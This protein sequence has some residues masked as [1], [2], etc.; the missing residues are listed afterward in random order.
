MSHFTRSPPPSQEATPPA[1][2]GPSAASTASRTGRSCAMPTISSCWCTAP[3]STPRRCVR[4][5]QPCWHRW[6]CGSH[7]PRPGSCTWTRG[8]TSRVPHPAAP[9]EGYEQAARVHVHRRSANPLSQGEDPC[10]DPQ[11]VT[12]TNGS[13][14][15]ARST[16][17]EPARVGPLFQARHREERVQHAGQLHGVVTYCSLIAKSPIRTL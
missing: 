11:D 1:R 5:S 4:T 7:R 3:G 10:T 2:G 14:V 9:Q 16:Q 8:S 17:H 6:G 15:P 12:V 13:G